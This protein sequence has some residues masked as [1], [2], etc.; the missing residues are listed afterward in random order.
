M[1]FNL[2]NTRAWTVPLSNG[3]SADVYEVRDGKGTVIWRKYY[4]VSYDSNAEEY[5]IVRFSPNKDCVSG[6]MPDMHV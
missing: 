6:D 5:W 2:F 3:T 4:R 1:D